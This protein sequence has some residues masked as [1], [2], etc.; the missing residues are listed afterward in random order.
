MKLPTVLCQATKFSICL[1]VVIPMFLDGCGGG[2]ATVL[3]HGS[4]RYGHQ[5]TQSRH[6]L[7]G[8]PPARWRSGGAGATALCSRES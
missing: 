6:G 8:E 5:H 2:G 1:I 4:M 7:V 3:F